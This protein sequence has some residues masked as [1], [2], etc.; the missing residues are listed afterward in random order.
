MRSTTAKLLS[1][2]ALVGG[3]MGTGSALAA[4]VSTWDYSVKSTLS[5]AV[6]TSGGGTQVTSDTRIEWGSSTNPAARSA[7]GVVDTPT[8]GSIMTNGPFEA[9]DDYYHDNKPILTSYADLKSA[10]LMVDVELTPTAPPGSSADPISFTFQINFRETE[11]DGGADGLCED[12][13]PSGVGKHAAGCRD[14]FAFAFDAG[15]VDFVYDGLTYTLFLFEDPTSAGFPKL[16][17]LEDGECLAAGVAA[18]CIGF[19]TEENALNIA[20]FVIEIDRVPE[21][22]MLGLFGLGLIGLGAA[23]RRRKA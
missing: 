9:A 7:I 11:N 10:K 14:I 2:A 3:L 19:T 18:G 13:L 16:T 15:S 12:G 17:F 8:T 4:P 5:D 6:F 20:E 1:A 23:R 22:A 21:P